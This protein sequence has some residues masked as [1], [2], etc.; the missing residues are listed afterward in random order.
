MRR[1][2]RVARPF[3]GRGPES[4]A[5]LIAL[6]LLTAHP[7]A[8]QTPQAVPSSLQGRVVKWGTADPISKAT[9]ELRPIA[10]GTPAPYVATT[11]AD[12]TFV[13]A[14][15]RPGQ[16][17]VVSTRPGYVSAEYGQRWPNGVGTP[18]TIPPGRTVNN[19]PIPMLQTAAISGR[20]RDRSGQPLGNVLVEAMKATYQD[21]RRVLTR[22]ESA[23]SDDRGEYRLFWL[24]PGRYYLVARHPDISGGL[25]RFGGAGFSAGGAG[26]GP[27]SL[28]QFQ[29]FRNNGDNAG[30]TPPLEVRLQRSVRERYMPV[31]F[32]GTTEEQAAAPIDLATGAEQTGTD[33]TVEPVLM[34]R[35]RGRVVYESNGEPAMSARVQWVSTTGGSEPADFL[36]MGRST[37]TPVECCNG[38]FE[39]ALPP[40]SYTLVAAVNNLNA[41]AIVQVGFAD[42]EG[43]VL[44]LGQS[45]SV[46]GRMT[47][48]GRAPAPE[49]LNAFRLSLAMN[50][51][52]PGI[53]P[54]SYS[55]VLPGGTLTLTAGRG[56]FRVNVSPLLNV[57]GAFQ[58]PARLIPPTSS[59]LYVK[60][61]RLG[62]ADVLNDGLHLDGKPDAALEIVIGTTPGSIEGLVVNESRQ[63]VPNVAVS[64]VPDVSRRRRMDL[65]K[66]ATTDSNGRFKIDHVP[67]GDYVAF[68]WD[69]FDSGDWQNPE[70]VAP[71]ESRGLPV[72]IRDGALSSVELAA[73]TPSR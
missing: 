12:G 54:D 23:V 70:F 45:F 16:Y 30:T 61:I 7:V 19:V 44:S 59:N 43:I 24:V 35:V 68:A 3:Q 48:E 39:L 20:I 46:A 15:V 53:Q 21:G 60:S 11:S 71:Y 40:G 14:A 32:P 66:I 51:P 34:Q 52:V 13:F 50:P 58:I 42:V 67:P 28:V 1:A 55:T 4:P 56:D 10:A 63:P 33:F 57:P 49:E 5:L 18:L 37:G 17:R 38:A 41:R 36:F 73:L 65:Y 25:M 8:G 29:E 69:G 31:Y 64:L 27:N 2:W 22:V 9:V 72:R 26:L 47:F 62:N 6:C